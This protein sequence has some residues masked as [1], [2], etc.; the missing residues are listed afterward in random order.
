[1]RRV[2]PSLSAKNKKAQQ[3]PYVPRKRAQ[4]AHLRQATF[5]AVN[6]AKQASDCLCSNIAL[7]VICQTGYTGRRST[8]HATENRFIELDTVSQHLASAMFA[9]WCQCMDCTFERIEFVVA[10]LEDNAKCIFIFIATAFTD[11]HHFLL[12]NTRLKD[13][14]FK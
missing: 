7:N 13:N 12:R 6:G 8:M 10:V 2:N 3:G 9:H 5:A 14:S 4:R 1:M 11:T